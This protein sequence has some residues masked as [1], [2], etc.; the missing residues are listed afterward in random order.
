M[1]DA[2]VGE[3]GTPDL[4]GLLRDLDEGFERAAAAQGEFVAHLVIAERPFRIRVAGAALAGALLPALDRCRRASGCSGVAVTEFRAWD[5]V[6]SGVTP[7]R[8]PWSVG[9]YLPR[10][11]L[12][13]SGEQGID[14]SYALADRIL[15]LWSRDQGLGRFWVNDASTLPSWEPG[16]PFRNLFHWALAD[17]GLAFAH[18][19]V[20]GTAAGGVLLAGRGG[21]GKS[22]T[23]M[24]CVD[25]GWRYVSDDY[26]VLEGS[27]HPTA[28]ALYGT[29]KISPWALERLPG[30]ASSGGSPRADGKV[31]LNLAT[32]RPTLLTDSLPLRAVVIPTVADAT[33]TLQRL[34]LAAGARA[35]APSTLFQLPGARQSS[36]GTIATILKRVPVFGLQVGP[37]LEA[38][39]DALR[40]ALQGPMT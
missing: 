2:R 9:D 6:G 5:S 31:V 36:L 20:V 15:S 27:G 10:D 28:H 30:L 40:P 24:V 34:S 32:A 38:I 39:P 4:G 29:A 33:G 17:R 21:A 18:A 25:A 7:P 23:S 13:G 22:T 11:E 8:P 3:P 16:A 37:D 14:V 26:C 12:R 19:A 1:Q 35:L